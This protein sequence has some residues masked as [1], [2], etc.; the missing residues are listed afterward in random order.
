[1]NFWA[2]RYLPAEPE[3]KRFQPFTSEDLDFKGTQE[4][5][6]SIAR[7]LGLPA[8]YPHKVEMTALAGVIPLQ[9]GDLKSSIEIV[10]RIPGISSAAHI[11]AFK[12]EWNGKII[13]VLDPISLLA[14]KL[15]LAATVPQKN[16][17]DAMHL[18]ILVSCVRAFLQEVLQQVERGEAPARDWL[19]AAN[20]TI[21]LTTSHRARKMAGK[22]QIDW[23]A[24]LPLSA[25]A[26]SKNEKIRRFHE[27]QLRQS[28]RKSKGK[29]Q[30]TS[31]G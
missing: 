5:V 23:P 13:R 24:V 26:Q 28:Y 31:G 10:R 2:E 29:G 30:V 17:R 14:S 4:D 15:E 1:M 18:K 16:R 27:Q 6:Q 12:T 25:I 22:H 21:K 7:Q 20:Q 8:G 19:G 9:I 3:L 11:P